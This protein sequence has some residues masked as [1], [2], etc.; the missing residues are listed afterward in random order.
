M[1]N[2]ESCENMV[3]NI[4]ERTKKETWWKTSMQN[5]WLNNVQKYGFKV[6]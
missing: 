6:K 2:V 3:E 5:K 4:N 1:K